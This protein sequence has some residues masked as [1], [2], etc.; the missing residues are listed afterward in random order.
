[1]QSVRGVFFYTL[2]LN[3]TITSNIFLAELYLGTWNNRSFAHK[4]ILSNKNK[5]F[6]GAGYRS[7]YLSHAKRALYHL[8]YAPRYFMY[9]ILF[10]C[11]N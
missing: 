10:T 5:G 11:L 9:L 3:C 4:I 8:S 2:S 7:R 6:G 1:M